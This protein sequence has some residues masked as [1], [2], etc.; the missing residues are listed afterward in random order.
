MA[1]R[2]LGAEESEKRRRDTQPRTCSAESIRK[3]WELR[4][5]QPRIAVSR[6]ASSI[7]LADTF[8]E[9]AADIFAVDEAT[10]LR[11]KVVAGRSEL[12]SKRLAGIVERC[13]EFEHFSQDAA[14]ALSPAPKPGRR[15]RPEVVTF[16]EKFKAFGHWPV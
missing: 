15:R 11:F 8:A 3:L 10:K 13:H 9:K 12:V 4:R 1:W 6:S 5:K 7:R 14:G 16:C 2:Q